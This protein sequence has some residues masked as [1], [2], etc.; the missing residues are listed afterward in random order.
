MVKK[1]LDE[2][3]LKLRKSQLARAILQLKGKPLDLEEYKPFEM[4]YDT[5]PQ[6]SLIKAGRQI[7]KSVSLGGMTV[8]ESIIRSYFNTLYLAP[9]SSQTSRFS[10]AYLDPFLY[11]PIIKKHFLDASS[12]KN[13]FEKSLNNGSRIYLSYACDELGSDRIRGASVDQL[14][15]DEIQDI[16]QEAIPVLKETLSASEFAFV[17]Y[18]G[19]AKTE[20]NT[21]EINWR[22]SNMLEWVVQCPHCG[23]YT[24]PNDFDTC[25]K[26]LENPDGP[27]CVHCGKVL[28]MKT[29]Q[30]LAAKPHVKDFYGYHCPQCIIPARCKPKKWKELRAKAFGTEGG[31]GYSTA[32]LANEVFGLASGVG[33]R[34]LSQ[35][36][37]MACC[38]SARTKFDEGFPTDGRGIVCTT[39][40]VDWS[41]SGST[42]SYTVITVLGYDFTGKC[43]VLFTERL[44]GVDILEQVRRVEYLYHKFKCTML[45]SDRGVGVLQG[46][47]MKQDL[48]DDKVNMINYVASKAQL[49]WD[50]EG[51]FFAAD[52]TMNIDTTVLKA[53]MGPSKFETPCWELMSEF[54][55]DALNVFEEETQAGRRVYRKDEDLTDDW[56]HSV[57]FANIAYM[58]VRG[59]FTYVDVDATRDSIFDF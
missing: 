42:K 52:R 58:I 18:T 46:Q 10:S 48:G 3:T 9:Y 16:S 7:G 17:R 32:K 30:W 35:R 54:W 33:G 39:L 57:T 26:I 8:A 53:K 49:R 31:R 51:L 59:D 29:G 11:S 37:A 5:S 15:L 23:K 41:V 13:V 14:F 1:P 56:L 40:G 20:N 19:T 28:D 6:E 43:Y 21:L 22:R 4:I 34:I 25:M 44:N 45:G 36:E 2:T 50:K 38:N 12:K 55:Q 27:G 24:I 47:L